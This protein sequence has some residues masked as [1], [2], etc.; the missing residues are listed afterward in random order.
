MP[1]KF[2]LVR[3]LILFF[4]LLIA[5]NTGLPLA[6]ISNSGFF[7]TRTYGPDQGMRATYLVALTQDNAG[8]LWGASDSTLYKREGRSF[9]AFPVPKIGTAEELVDLI[10]ADDGLWLIYRNGVAFYHQGKTENSA[11]HLDDTKDPFPPMPIPGVGVLYSKSGKAILAASPGRTRTL[12]LPM[13]WPLAIWAESFQGE[14]VLAS[15]EGLYVGNGQQWQFFPFSFR[16]RGTPQSL[17]RDPKRQIWLRTDKELL[18]FKPAGAPPQNLQALTGFQSLNSL[19]MQLDPLGRVWVATT[20][21]LLWMDGNQ[22]GFLGEAEG[23]PRT[24]SDLPFTFDQ[25]GQLW[26]FS[27]SLHRLRGNFLWS[28]Y[29]RP[30]GLPSDVAWSLLRQRDGTFWAGTHQGLARLRAGRFETLAGTNDHL[31]A[32]LGEDGAGNLWAGGAFPK[33]SPFLFFKVAKGQDRAEP[34][35]IPSW[36]EDAYTFGLT[37]DPAGWFWVASD[38]QGLLKLHVNGPSP[39]LERIEI[40]GFAP[41]FRVSQVI[42]DHAG[43]IWA[44]TSLGLAILEQGTWSVIKENGPQPNR[45]AVRADGQVWVSFTGT[46]GLDRIVRQEGSWVR[47]E[48]VLPPNSLVSDFI[49]AMKVDAQDQLW[50]STTGGVKCWDGK[51]LRRYNREWG[52]ASEDCAQGALWLDSDRTLWVGTSAGISRMDASLGVHGATIPGVR[53]SRVIDGRGIELPLT[54]PSQKVPFQSASLTFHYHAPNIIGADELTYLVRLTG[55]ESDWR[56]TLLEESRFAGL[57]PGRYTFEVRAQGW[58]GSLGP[59]TQFP[60][61]IHP[62]WYLAG[63]FA[64]LAGLALLAGLAGLYRWRTNHLSRRN[65][66]LET[67][68]RERTQALSEANQALLQSSLTDALTGLHNRHYLHLVRKEEEARTRRAF[69]QF[70]DS[71]KSPLGQ[72]EDLIFLLLDLDYFKR[73]NDTYGHLA[74]DEVLRQVAEV[75]RG[76]SREMDSQIRWGGEE[77]L[78]IARRTDRAK[79]STIACH[80]HEAIAAHPFRLPDGQVIRRTVSVGFVAFPLDPWRPKVHDW[81][82]ALAAADQCLYAA[83]HSGRNGWVGVYAMTPPPEALSAHHLREDLAAAVAQNHL[84]LQTSFSNPDDLNWKGEVF[85]LLP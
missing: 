55:L 48:Q 57:R 79:A 20:K 62:P 47:V 15:Q 28:N 70:S 12:V 22:H 10:A 29:A 11:F 59:I 37:W 30:Q 75:I 26:F 80:I 63:W 77:F 54:D 61:L 78:V 44:A 64:A 76:A 38:N 74:G 14:L 46:K 51:V 1:S 60:I 39:R 21:G 69:Q 67:L 49:M 68:V 18:C 6:A 16:L 25:T 58:E 85:P 24:G 33:G 23:L 31:L 13:P 9:R 71:G 40:P 2:S 81:D 7:T 83:K 73:V 3:V 36:N 19:G 34:V 82:E 42:R 41:K 45:L 50:L 52:L 66:L 17:L 8:S 5:G 84:V 32:A 43:R 65:L 53:I 4:W 35:R 56:S 27:G 72:E